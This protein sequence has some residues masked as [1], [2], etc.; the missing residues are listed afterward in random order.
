M[1][2]AKLVEFSPPIKTKQKV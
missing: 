1:L 2:I